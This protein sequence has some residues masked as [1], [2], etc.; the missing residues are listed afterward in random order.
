MAAICRKPCFQD[1]LR[2]YAG[3]YV[4]GPCLR[5]KSSCCVG[6]RL[7]SERFPGC[8]EEVPGTAGRR[9]PLVACCS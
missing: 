2:M 6:G 3:E 8:L 7:E 9:R 1:R 4:L 5:A